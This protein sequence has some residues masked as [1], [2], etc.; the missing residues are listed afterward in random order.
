MGMNLS[1]ENLDHSFVI[2]PRRESEGVG[3]S[4]QV[5]HSWGRTVSSSEGPKTS[6]WHLHI[7]QSILDSRPMKYLLGACKG[8][9]PGCENA[10]GKLRQR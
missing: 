5:G 4:S 2:A 1:G 10:T 9:A 7:N 3:Q 6:R 8:L